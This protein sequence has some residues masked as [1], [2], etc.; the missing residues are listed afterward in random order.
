MK[1]AVF[2]WL[3]GFNALGLI[4]GGPEGKHGGSLGTLG[5]GKGGG[6]NESI[7]CTLVCM[8]LAVVSG[9]DE[10]VLLID[11]ALSGLSE[12]QFVPRVEMMNVLL[13]VRGLLTAVAVPR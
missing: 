5:R 11:V 13:D 9:V 10:A 4:L 1:G 12:R 3:C 7:R 8:D 6:T 2:G